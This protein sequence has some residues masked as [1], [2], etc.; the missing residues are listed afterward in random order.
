MSKTVFGF[1]ILMD[2]IFVAIVGLFKRIIAEQQYS[3]LAMIHWW[4]Y[5]IICR[6]RYIMVI[7]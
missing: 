5:P 4:F 7:L 2:V 3:T 1:N 6:K